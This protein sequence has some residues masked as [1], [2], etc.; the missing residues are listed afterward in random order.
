MIETLW[1]SFPQSEN[2]VSNN[3]ILTIGKG[4]NILVDKAKALGYKYILMSDDDYEITSSN[5]MKSLAKV[6]LRENADI[7]SVRRDDVWYST[8]LYYFM[9]FFCGF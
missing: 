3:W 5:I 7:V 1:R 6:I 2:T 4:R 8:G 9:L